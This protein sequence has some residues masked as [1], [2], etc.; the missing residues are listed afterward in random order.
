LS[1]EP[2]HNERILLEAIHAEDEKAFEEIF[3]GYKD[4]VFNIAM[5]YTESQELS[6]EIVQDVFV[7]V[8]S[9]RKELTAIRD[10]SSWIF[11]LTRNRSFNVL[12][13]TA[14]LQSHQQELISHLP[15]A[16]EGDELMIVKD[17][18]KLINEA[19]QLLSPSQKQAFELFKIQGLSREETA[20]AMN[21]SPNT[22]KVHLLHALRT[23]RAYLVING[24]VSVCIL[25]HYPLFL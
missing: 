19:L 22:V 7:K 9:K 3:M 25:I 1:N 21:L 10:F 6:E 14:T 16:H 2:I 17:T 15:T 8:W 12:R 23:I 11:T 5:L 24:V 13:D 4:R 18:E 20:R